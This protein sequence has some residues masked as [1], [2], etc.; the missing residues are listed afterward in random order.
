VIRRSWSQLICWPVL[1]WCKLFNIKRCRCTAA[2][3]GFFYI[4]LVSFLNLGLAVSC[5]PPS[6]ARFIFRAV[7]LDGPAHV[8]IALEPAS[9]S[10]PCCGP[11]TGWGPSRCWCWRCCSHG[12]TNVLLQVRPFMMGWSRDDS[13][14]LTFADRRTGAGLARCTRVR[15]RE[16]G[17]DPHVVRGLVFMMATIALLGAVIFVCGRRCTSTSDPSSW[18]SGGGRRR[19]IGWFR[20][21]PPRLCAAATALPLWIGLRR[22][23]RF[24]FLA[25]GEV[26][27]ART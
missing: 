11:N 21:G 1:V 12:L 16:R 19:M 17:P 4:T 23:E 25:R 27:P 7:S 6:P 13:R 2:G 18:G 20:R 9:T 3:G 24:E 10:A 14:R 15:D 22:I 8:A 5:S 26:E